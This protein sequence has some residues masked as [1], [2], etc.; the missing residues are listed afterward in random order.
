[1]ALTEPAG[2]IS[3]A[4]H[5]TNIAFA[6]AAVFRTWTGTDN[7]AD[8]LT[9]IHWGA[10]SDPTTYAY[11]LGEL[12]DKRPYVLLQT[13]NSASI[14]VCEPASGDDNGMIIGEF[15]QDVDSEIAT[16]PSEIDRR[17]MNFLG[18]L[19]KQV[20]LLGRTAGHI[21]VARFEVPLDGWHR[22]DEDD[23]VQL[24]DHIWAEF[25][26]DWGLV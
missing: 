16:N 17:F 3:L 5:Y 21:E 14:V 24:G 4:Q 12:Q 18:T 7:Q 10:L 13:R 15:V 2:A 9:H 25:E 1:M 8:A 26:L 20:I 6:D 19:R 22:A 23:R 11:M